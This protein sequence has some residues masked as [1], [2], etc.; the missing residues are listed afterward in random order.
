ME[1]K[2]VCTNFAYFF[3]NSIENIVK[4]RDEVCDLMLSILNVKKR[5]NLP[6]SLIFKSNLKSVPIGILKKEKGQ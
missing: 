5:A 6:S 2:S 3:Q 1:R 4:N